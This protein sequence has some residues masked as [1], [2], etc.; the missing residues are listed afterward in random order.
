MAWLLGLS[1]GFHSHVAQAPGHPTLSAAQAPVTIAE[2]APCAEEHC[3]LCD[4]KAH[5]PYVPT[6][7]PQ[8]A[9]A[10]LVSADRSLLPA[11]APPAVLVARFHSRAPPHVLF[12]FNA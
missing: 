4:W 1:G 9:T 5:T 11:R 2:T 8:P 3:V 7:E 12:A 6:V 10:H